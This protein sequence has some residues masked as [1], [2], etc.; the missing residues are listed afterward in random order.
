MSSST[1]PAAPSTHPRS[2]ALRTGAVVVGAAVAAVATWAAW[3]AW[4]SGYRTDPATGAVSGPYAGWQVAGCVLTLVLV[5]AVA[6]WWAPPWF[7]AP[8]VTLAFTAAWAARAAATDDTGLFAVGAVFLLV[9][10][11][12]GSALVCTIAWLVHRHRHRHRRGA[13][14]AG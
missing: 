11:G 9:G 7:V 12:T 10:L 13:A 2:T 8:A 6:G 4:E 14:P 1:D 5:A 3:L